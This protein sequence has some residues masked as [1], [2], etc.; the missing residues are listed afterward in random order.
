MRPARLRLGIVLVV[1]CVLFGALVAAMDARRATAML[2]AASWGWIPIG[3]AATAASYFCLSAGYALLNRIF[4]IELGNRDLLEIGFVSTALNNLVSMA[5]VAGYSL[6]LLL[7]RRR[8]VAAGDVVGASLVHSYLN[9]LVMLSLLPAGLLY[10]LVNHPLGRTRSVALAVAT[11][12]ATLV[13]AA[14][15]W[16]LVSRRARAGV[17]AGLAAVARIVLRRDVG[18]ALR[19]LDTRLGRGVEAIRNRPSVLGAPLLCVILDWATSVAALGACFAA[20]GAPLHP[21]VLLTG[22]AIGVTA[23]FLSMLPGGLGV[24]EGSMAAIYVLLGVDYER[25]VLAAMLFRIL[26][27]IVPF[28]V[29]LGLYARLMRGTV[30]VDTPSARNQKVTGP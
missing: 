20:F 11:G 29:S 9:H 5:G 22:F 24:Q 15:T 1:V 6:R 7:L 13:L 2:G 19:D 26:Y 28:G 8:G 16:M 3:L 17:A 18:A 23:G 27:Y 25:A 12:L 21:G 30:P 10:L 14:T 4:G